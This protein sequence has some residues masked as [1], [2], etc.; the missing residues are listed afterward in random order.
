[1][2]TAKN[3]PDSPPEPSSRAQPAIRPETL[4]EQIAHGLRRDILRGAL[5]PGTPVKERDH[6]TDLG[7]SRTPM[8]EAIR[9]LAQEGLVQLRPA[10]SPIVAAPSF[11]EI[12]QHIEVLT[13]LEVLSAK[14]ACERATSEQIAQIA[15]LADEM[16]AHY[17][18]RDMLDVFEIDMAFHRAIVAAAHNPVLS[19]M[20]GALLAR[21][22]R[23]RYLSASRKRSRDRALSQHAAMVTALQA[24]DAGATSAHVLE[25][26][27]HLLVNVRE[28]FDSADAPAKARTSAESDPDPHPD[29]RPESGPEAQVDPDAPTGT[30]PGPAAQSP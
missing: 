23:A 29:L 15:A 13:A 25:H 24:R 9:I 28:F 7:V 11:D 4:P 12:A 8:R 2:P 16:A 21:L 1:M 30:D 5:P 27:E 19:E 17:D 20:H 14:L 18:S 26:L 22:W 6:A 3:A 10:R